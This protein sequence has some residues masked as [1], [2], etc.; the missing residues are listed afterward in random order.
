MRKFTIK[1]LLVTAMLCLSTSAFAAL[2]E[3]WSIDFTEIGANYADLTDLTIDKSSP[4]LSMGAT[5][6][7]ENSIDSKFLLQTDTRWS[8]RKANGLYQF[9]SGGRA[10]GLADCKAGQIITISSTGAPSANTNVSLTSS[11]NGTYV[12]TVTAD[13]PVKFNL[14]RYLYI[15]TIK[16][17]ENVVSDD[18]IGTQYTI[19][20][21][22]ETETEI[23]TSVVTDSYVGEVATA[24]NLQM[25]SFFNG[26]ATKKYIYKS[27]NEEIELV[28]DAT[29]NVI[30]LVY[31]EAA[32]YTYTVNATYGT[33]VKQITTGSNFEGETVY[34]AYNKY[35]NNDGTLYEKAA[36]NNQFN[37]SFVLTENNKVE[38][39][40]Y[41]ATDITDVVYWSEAEEI[42]GATPQTGSNA[43]V[44]CSNSIGASFA[45]NTTVVNLPAGKYKIWAQVWGNATTTFNILA[46]ETIVLSVDTKG[47]IFSGSNEF[48]L[49]SDTEI[50]IAKAGNS[51]RM[52]DCLYIQKT[53][54]ATTTQNVTVGSNGIATFTPSVALDFTNA[55]SIKA[56]TATVSETTVTLTETKTVAAGEGVIIQSVNGGEATEEI[57]VANPATATEG[58]ALVGTLVDIAN[59]ATTDGTY[60][61]YILNFVDGKAGF[62]QA[63]NKKV[64]A[65][66][67]YLQVPVANGAKALTIVWNDGETTGIEENYEFG[68]VNS[69]VATFDLSGRKIANPAKGLYIKNGKKFIV[70]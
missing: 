22:D 60:N 69:D 25:A 41:S 7:G 29:Q 8:L 48:N 51:G 55:T 28:E 50:I 10:F 12:F 70:K 24:T 45:E 57:A 4:I 63:N 42:V 59:L 43:N 67:A 30:T 20:Y 64:A 38:N 56:Y 6:V 44:R 35:I 37:G 1:S 23:K 68:T 54:D 40:A 2:E 66:K 17:E 11:E 46:G 61:N 26:D 16:I 39:V 53:G 21:V 49:V 13:G 33:N 62:Y 15:T 32:T 9:N 58:N 14:A 19:K 3:V 34:Y 52:L 27:G 47:Y 65:G 18:A 5:S 31:R 36:I